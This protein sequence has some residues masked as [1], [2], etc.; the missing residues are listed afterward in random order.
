MP[1][2]QLHHQPKVINTSIYNFSIANIY[3]SLPATDKCYTVKQGSFYSS[4]LPFNGANSNTTL[5]TYAKFD[6]NCAQY[7]FSDQDPMGHLCSTSWNKL[8]GTVRCG[9]LNSNHK[10]SDRFVWRR[11]QKCL[12]YNSP[13]VT[14]EVENCDEQD[15]IEI[16]AYSYDN[17]DQPFTSENQGR[18]LKIFQ[19]KLYV[20]TW[21]FLKLTLYQTGAIFE[22]FTE[23]GSLIERQTIDHRDCGTSYMYGLMQG[24]YFG[25]QCPAPQDVTVCFRY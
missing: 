16:A 23:H 19:N 11:A 14:G 9:I 18:L 25:G 13:Y 7:L 10:D 17:G 3:S 22:V 5:A 20:D 6:R 4:I 15:L 12:V 2:W 8:W 1:I 24:L 21:Y